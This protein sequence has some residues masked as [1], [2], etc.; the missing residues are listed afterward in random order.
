MIRGRERERGRA[1]LAAA[2]RENSCPRFQIFGAGLTARGGRVCLRNCFR[3]CLPFHHDPSRPVWR[4]VVGSAVRRGVDSTVSDLLQPRHPADHVGHVLSLPR[5]R[6]EDPGSRDAARRA[7]GRAQADQTRPDPHR[8]RQTRGERNHPAHH[9]HRRSDAAGDDAQ[10]SHAGAEG[11]LPSLGRRGRGLRTALGLHAARE[12]R[13]AARKESHESHRRVYPGAPRR[14]EDQALAGGRENPAVATGFVGF[15]RAAADRG[16]DGGV[17]RR[18]VAQ[19]LRKTG[20]APARLASSRRAHGGVV[21]RYRALQRHGR[22]SRR[23]EPAHLPVSRLRDQRLQ[24]QQALRS[25]HSRATRRRPLAQSDDRAARRDRLQ[26]AQHDDPRRRCPVR[27]ISRE[28]RGRAGAGR[29]GRVVRQH[30][31]LRGVPRPQ[32]RPDQGE[33]FLRAAVFLR[34]C[35]AVGRLQRLRLHA[36]SGIKGVQQRLSVSARARGRKS[37]SRRSVCAHE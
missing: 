34:R 8:P 14:A 15:D 7:R 6:L 4:I 1:F 17:P 31:W 29:F 9:G 13:S 27:R 36:E 28:I 23:S 32:I 19:R 10:E 5:F 3:N 25:V 24:H 30:L 35:E 2:G 33:G 20:R 11:T 22:F 26:P 18:P 21:A 16:G 37:V 12:T